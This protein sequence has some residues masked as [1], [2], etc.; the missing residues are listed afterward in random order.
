ML[1]W[2]AANWRVLGCAFVG[3]AF[4]GLILLD[5]MNVLPGDWVSS[6]VLAAL[7]AGAIVVAACLLSGKFE[8][9]INRIRPQIL[10][11]IIALSVIA[12]ITISP[13]SLNDSSGA[14]ETPIENA[15]V[16]PL[17]AQA[18]LFDKEREVL[19]RKASRQNIAALA[20]GGLIALATRLLESEKGPKGTRPSGNQPDEDDQSTAG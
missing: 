9:T 11:A 12:L 4:V 19:E 5:G 18:A 8:L 2:M 13:I 6:I 16:D 17:A 14:A 3:L 7:G 1:Q 15:D 10:F 20:V